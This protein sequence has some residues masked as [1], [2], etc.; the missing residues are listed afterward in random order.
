MS[1]NTDGP[2]AACTI[3]VLDQNNNYD[4]L[5]SLPIRDHNDFHTLG[6]I[7][8]NKEDIIDTEVNLLCLV[9]LSK[10]K[11]SLKKFR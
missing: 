3:V 11:F 9:I 7:L 4:N 6:D 8:A 10:L 2:Y 5:I 1:E